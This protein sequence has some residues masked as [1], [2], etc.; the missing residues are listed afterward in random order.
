MNNCRILAL[1]IFN[2]L[3]K[4]KKEKILNLLSTKATTHGSI[5]YTFKSI[6]RIKKINKYSEVLV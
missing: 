1:K 4:N 2:Y 6:L 5:D 3:L